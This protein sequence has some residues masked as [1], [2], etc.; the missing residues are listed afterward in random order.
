MPSLKHYKKASSDISG[1]RWDGLY[2]VD[3][4]PGDFKGVCDNAYE[5]L[6]KEGRAITTAEEEV[7]LKVLSYDRPQINLGFRCIA[8]YR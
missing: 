1:K 6:D 4:D 2:P 5:M 3:E 7:C 8:V